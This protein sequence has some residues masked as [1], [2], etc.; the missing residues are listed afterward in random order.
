MTEIISSRQN[1]KVKQARSLRQ[2]KN[3]ASL[4]LYLAEGLHHIGAAI[5]AD[6]PI[7]YL[8]YAPEILNSDFGSELLAQAKQQ[9]VDSF[10]VSADVFASIAEKDNP[11]GVLAVVRQQ[12]H[13][14]DEFSPANLGWGVALVAP[15]DPGNVGTI[16][17]TMDAVDADGL[18]LLD[19]GV[20]PYHPTAV[21]ASMGALFWHPLIQASF[22]DF[23]V[24]VKV[25]DYHVY[26]SS[27]KAR[28]DYRQVEYQKPAILL[29]GS[30]QKGLTQE[31]VEICEKVVRLTM[32]GHVT[33]LN[34]AVATSILLYQF[35][36][37]K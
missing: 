19:G 10:P 26:G 11:Q 23:A 34:L 29:M 7:A 28:Q 33:S 21:R 9:K 2:R 27:A 36:Q 24:W 18:I 4:G 25:H 14:L 30:E 17:R 8:L 16:L 3:R 6:A 12:P 32:E 20:D 13:K 35:H 15:Q 37:M 5:E 31:Q 22:E 1:A